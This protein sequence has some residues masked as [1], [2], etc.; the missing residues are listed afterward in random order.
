MD[1]QFRNGKGK[2][3]VK[4]G[5]VSIVVPVYNTGKYLNRCMNSIVKQTYSNI[6][7]IL[8]D[9]GSTDDSS[10]LCDEW[11]E[12]DERIK[13]IHKLNAGLGMARNTGIENAKGE[14]ICFFDSD[15]YI[16]LQTIEKSYR[17]A[18]KSEADI[19]CF[20]YYKVSEKGKIC[21]SFIPNMPKSEYKGIEIQIAFLPELIQNDPDNKE[22]TN[23]CMSAW[24]SLY[25]MTIIQKNKWRFVSEREII[26]EDY[27]SLLYLYR[28]VEKI[29]VLKAACYFYCENQGSLTHVFQ[30]NRY[31]KI[32]H[33]YLKSLE[34][35]EVLNYGK[36]IKKRVSYTYFAN[37]L[38]ALK[39]IMAGNI[40]YKEKKNLIKSVIDDAT[41][42][43][44]LD[45]IKYD[46]IP[47]T[48]RIFLI[49]MRRKW[50]HCCCFLLCLQNKRK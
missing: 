11:A 17:L 4:Q 24:A 25:S 48:W 36:K 29:A 13:V 1:K 19:V 15:D 21:G 22:R 28:Y 27:Y 26:S 40:E 33:Y 41:C 44:V 3:T 12:K 43:D 42:R 39:Q 30:K 31:E 34:A 20:G 23:L 2:N 14:Y 6:E 32:R 49:A 10:D 5:L 37:T 47:L 7:V 35:C 9:D 18:C 8:I 50:S 16:D 45:Q 38:G 46:R